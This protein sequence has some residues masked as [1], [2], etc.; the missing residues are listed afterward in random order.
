[1]IINDLENEIRWM[2]DNEGVSIAELGR[3]MGVSRQ[4]ASRAAQ[5]NRGA[6]PKAFVQLAE[7]LGY[8]LKIVYVQK[9]KELDNKFSDRQ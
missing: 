4:R 6:V 5:T 8:D 3:R 7:A 1:M 2:C 9:T